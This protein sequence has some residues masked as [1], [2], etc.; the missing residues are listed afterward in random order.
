LLL[1]LFLES[2]RL[3]TAP[4]ENEESSKAQKQG[5]RLRNEERS[6][7]VAIAIAVEDRLASIEAESRNVTDATEVS[8][9]S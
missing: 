9:V 1:K 5:A 6:P 8:R 7:V 3:A 2:T 4:E